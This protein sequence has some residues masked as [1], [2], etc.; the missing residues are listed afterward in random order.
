MLVISDN[1]N[2]ISNFYSG[3]E[4]AAE[5]GTDC[6]QDFVIIANPFIV[7]SAVGVERFCGNGFITKTCMYILMFFQIFV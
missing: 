3:P 7:G 1:N 5:Q 6:T 4:F 2:N